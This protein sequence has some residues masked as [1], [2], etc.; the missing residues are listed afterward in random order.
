MVGEHLSRE[1]HTL[2]RLI[3]ATAQARGTD[4]HQRFLRLERGLPVL[5]LRLGGRPLRGCHVGLPGDSQGAEFGY[6]PDVITVHGSGERSSR[7]WPRRLDGSFNVE[8]A[9]EHLVKLVEV[10]LA[11]PVPELQVPRGLPISRSSLVVLHLAAVK[12]GVIEPGTEPEVLVGKVNDAKIKKRIQDHLDRGGLTDGDLH[13]LAEVNGMF[14]SR[15]TKID[16]DPF[17]LQSDRWVEMLRLGRVVNG[18]VE[19][20]FV[21]LLDDHDLTEFTLADPVGAGIVKLS[22]AELTEAWTLGARKGVKWVGTV[23]ANRVSQEEVP[24]ATARS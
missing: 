22:R 20:R 9:V 10:E 5:R 13:R 24:P 7:A 2:A 11:R 23:S 14:F 18:Q 21:A 19:H 1:A 17:E 12:L 3:L 15:P 4:L 6:A 16:F 8:A